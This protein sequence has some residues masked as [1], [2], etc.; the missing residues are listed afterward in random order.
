MEE[1]SP[2][3][4]YDLSPDEERIHSYRRSE[5]CGLAGSAQPGPQLSPPSQLPT[6]ESQAERSGGPLETLERFHTLS[7]RSHQSQGSSSCISPLHLNPFAVH[8]P[9]GPRKS[10]MVPLESPLL[11]ARGLS[12]GSQCSVASL[13]EGQESPDV[14]GCS[15]E[16]VGAESK[17]KTKVAAGQLAVLG[18]VVEN[19]AQLEMCSGLDPLRRLKLKHGLPWTAQTILCVES[20]SRSEQN[21][22]ERRRI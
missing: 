3:L 18:V 12:P 8:V 10:C 2:C 14:E 17:I 5:A 22:L 4:S 9:R 16:A 15:T 7:S 19:R 21:I 6:S 11:A 13:K 20:G 1:G